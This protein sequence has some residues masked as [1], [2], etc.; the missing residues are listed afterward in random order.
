M[1]RKACVEMVALHWTDEDQ[2]ERKSL[3]KALYKGI[4]IR[5]DQ[6]RYA[7]PTRTHWGAAAPSDT[8]TR[9]NDVV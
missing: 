1:R 6:A 8:A 5:P 9:H 2:K 7:P 4:T 3:R